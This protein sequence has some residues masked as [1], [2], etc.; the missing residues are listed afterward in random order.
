MGYNIR[1]SDKLTSPH[2]NNKFAFIKN[3]IFKVMEE[4]CLRLQK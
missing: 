4:L 3:T 2:P 1:V